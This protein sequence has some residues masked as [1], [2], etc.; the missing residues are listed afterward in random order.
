MDCNTLLDIFGTAENPHKC[1]LFIPFLC[2]NATHIIRNM[3]TSSKK[4]TFHISNCW[5]PNQC[6]FSKRRAPKNDEDPLKK[7]LKI[8]DTGPTSIKKMK[9]A[10]GNFLKPRNH[11]TIKPQNHKTTKL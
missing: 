1:Y 6:Q 8:I 2:R 5:T 9:W 3:G 4:N 11:K 10:F 7:F